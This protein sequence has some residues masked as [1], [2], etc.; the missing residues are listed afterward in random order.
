MSQGRGGGGGGG[1]QAWGKGVYFNHT[2][3]SAER[4]P[5]TQHRHLLLYRRMI[6][7]PTCK[8]EPTVTGRSNYSNIRMFGFIVHGCSDGLAAFRFFFARNRERESKFVCT[9]GGTTVLLSML[10]TCVYNTTV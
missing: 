10:Q 9:Y 8:L 6:P 5:R 2:D 7:P 1:H 4:M 3:G